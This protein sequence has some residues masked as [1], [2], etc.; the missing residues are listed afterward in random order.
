MNISGKLFNFCPILLQVIFII[1][2][3]IVGCLAM[4]TQENQYLKKM[5]KNRGVFLVYVELYL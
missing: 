2:H 5:L 4:E 3:E 1:N